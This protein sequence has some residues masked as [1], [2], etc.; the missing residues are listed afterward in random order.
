MDWGRARENLGQVSVLYKLVSCCG[1]LQIC[2]SR[3]FGSLICYCFHFYL[4]KIISKEH[5]SL[6]TTA[7]DKT[8]F[9]IVYIKR[10]V[11]KKEVVH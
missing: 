1:H 10:V 8:L 4:F 11:T 3:I 2:H 9:S 7:Q 5:S 6:Q